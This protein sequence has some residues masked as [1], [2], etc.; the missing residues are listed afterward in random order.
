MNGD[1]SGRCDQIDTVSLHALNALPRE[2]VLAL[3]AH[4]SECAECRN[5]MEA[6]RRTVDSFAFW[7][8]DVLRPPPS[9]WDRLA[10]QVG[11]EA[12]PGEP[13]PDPQ[14]EPQWQDVAPGISCKLLATD[15][16]ASR[17]SMLVRLA[18]E[19]DYPPHQ[20]GGVEEL[21]LL[22]GELWIDE[23]KLYPGDFNRA[24]P[25]TVDQRV[26]SE[27]GCTCLLVTSTRD[28]LR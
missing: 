5:E 8:T 21:H 15:T 6:L 24:E 22:Q 16:E 17:V 20:H 10:R 23:R 3:E 1:S 27:T 14:P 19:T 13:P 26:W 4:F 2:Q 9:L 28:L 12:G 7:P 18:P 25:G 11:V